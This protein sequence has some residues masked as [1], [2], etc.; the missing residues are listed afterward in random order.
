MLLRGGP[1]SFFG[2]AAKEARELHRAVNGLRAAVRKKD[3]AHAGPCGE[4]ARK[5]ALIGAMKEIREGNGTRG[6]SPDYFHDARMR[7]AKGVASDA[8]QKS[9]RFFTRGIET[10]R[11]AAVGHDHGR[12]LIGGQE[13]LF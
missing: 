1:G 11:A 7:M 5:R 8:A 10:E 2:F 4:F 3:A 12:A 13:E 6:F 9:E